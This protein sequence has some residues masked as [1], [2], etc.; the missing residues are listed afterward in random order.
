MDESLFET[1]VFGKVVENFLS[2][3]LGNYLLGQAK[4]E[5][6]EAM[7]LLVKTSPW[8]RRRIQQLQNQVW[9]AQQFQVWLA[10]AIVAG[11][12]A[13]NLLEGE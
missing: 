10:D 6:S 5:E 13:T 8:R 12:Q 4:E 11:Q 3:D 2:S 7:L 9:R 1:A